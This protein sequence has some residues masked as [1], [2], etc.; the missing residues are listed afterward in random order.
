MPPGQV[1]QLD[2]PDAP[3]ARRARRAELPH[4]AAP[5]GGA[6]R[7][8]RSPP[9]WNARFSAIRRAYRY[10]HPQPPRPPG[11]A[12]GRVWH[13]PAPLDAAAMADAAAL[14]LGRHDFTS[15]PRR[16]LPGQQ[17][18]AHAGPAG[19]ARDGDLISIEAEARS[20][21]HH[22]VRNIVGTL[23]LVGDG[24]WPPSRVAAA[25]AARDRAAAGPT[26]PPDG[27]TLTAVR[28][29]TD[30]FAASA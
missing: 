13:V 1:A 9:G 27:L 4:E 20:F 21:L 28:Y 16:R 5:R 7:G 6:A 2:L 12:R 23:K 19:R 17:P 15:L 8:A 30:P 14:L 10:V 26:A 24:T 25:L 29:E 11:A 18:A 22:Q 3:T